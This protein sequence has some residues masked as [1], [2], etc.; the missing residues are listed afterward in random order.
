MLFAVAFQRCCA[1]KTRA[2]GH[3]IP[4][5][6]SASLSIPQPTTAQ[7]CIQSQDWYIPKFLTLQPTVV[8]WDIRSQDKT[9]LSHPQRLGRSHHLRS[10][11]HQCRTEYVFHPMT[12]MF[13]ELAAFPSAFHLISQNKLKNMAR[14]LPF[15]TSAAV[16]TISSVKRTHK[17]NWFQMLC[18]L[19]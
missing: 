2:S 7:W 17:N 5:T 19:H 16:F 18:R 13:A 1:N 3:L 11:S 12:S 10:E 14:I 4:T 8:Q 6:S 15:K 9:I